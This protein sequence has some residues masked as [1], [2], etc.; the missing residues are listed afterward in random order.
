MEAGRPRGASSPRTHPLSSGS[1]AGSLDPAGAGPY[2]S[3]LSHMTMAGPDLA[4]WLEASDRREESCQPVSPRPASSRL[5]SSGFSVVVPPAPGTEIGARTMGDPRSLADDLKR[6]AAAEAVA[7]VESGMRLGL[8][9]GSTVAHF[10]TLLGARVEIGE[11]TGVVGVPTSLRTADRCRELGIQ[12]GEL[13]DLAPLD[14]AVDGADEVD[15]SLDLIKGLGGALLREK[16]V[17]T[18][19]RRFIVIADE[20]KVVSHLGERHPIPVEV[21]TFAWRSHLPFFEQLGAEPVLRLAP[22]GEPLRTDNGNYI[23]DCHFSGGV[24]DPASLELRIRGRAGVVA[25][26]LFLGM[27]SDV[28]IA[29]TTGVRRLSKAGLA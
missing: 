21:V 11:I 17:A 10:L 9:S 29:D 6:A 23:L 3:T 14:L 25:T 16:V 7:I 28:F 15:P 1:V 4:E 12:L 8:G 26:G 24:P 20:S 18:E 2:L 13:S 22:D 19:A 27:A 5:A